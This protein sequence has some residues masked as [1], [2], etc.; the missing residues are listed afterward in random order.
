MSEFYNNAI[1][2]VETEKIKP[3]PYQPRREF[4]Q[5]KLEDLAKSIRQYGVIQPLTVT[6]KEFEKQD[7]GLATEYELIAGER[8][9]RAAR[10][11]GVAQVPVIIRADYDDDKTKLEVAIIENLQREDLNPMD[12]AHAFAR[13]VNEF[14]FKHVQV[15]E[16]VGKSREY[17]S[18]TIR[19]L[20]LPQDV[21]TALTEG[22]ISEGHA[23][24][25]LM[26][27]DRPQEQSV[28]FREI[29]QKKLTVRDTESI[30]RR[31]AIDRVRRKEYLYSPEIIDMERELTE[32]LGTRVMIEPKE[33]GGKLSIDFMGEDDLRILFASLASRIAQG[34]AAQKPTSPQHGESSAEDS[35][36]SGAVAPTNVSDDVV[37]ASP[38]AIT[39]APD[40]K[41]SELLDD[42]SKEEKENDENSFDPSNFSL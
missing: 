19:L 24:P 33:N 32:A 4:D 34:P 36:M 18:N 10:L 15:A 30:A 41:A 3:N 25:L 7:G 11:A 27:V 28:L 31:I 12:R 9:L 8:R 5:A 21:Q 17:V 26:L 40:E 22:K 23:R 42:R 37:S 2:W 13:L 20:A 16:K 35:P 6:R 39:P 29:M 1:F 38:E 14:G